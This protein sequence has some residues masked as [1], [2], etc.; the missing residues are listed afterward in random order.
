[1]SQDQ[2]EAHRHLQLGTAPPSNRLCNWSFENFTKASY[3]SDSFIFKN[4]SYSSLIWFSRSVIKRSQINPTWKS[5]RYVNSNYRGKDAPR[6]RTQ[7]PTFHCT[8][9]MVIYSR[10]TI[11]KR[12]P[13]KWLIASKTIQEPSRTAANESERETV[14]WQYDVETTA[15]QDVFE[16]HSEWPS[17]ES[18]R[19]S[20]RRLAYFLG[21]S[22]TER[23]NA[24]FD[25]ITPVNRLFLSAKNN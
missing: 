8:F 9:A 11:R 17:N 18:N 4:R 20:R 7:Q 13:E 6:S 14:E 22:I 19:S 2:R 1:M 5:I 15:V 21:L 12:E 10:L 16:I 23:L 3:C 24:A 25:H